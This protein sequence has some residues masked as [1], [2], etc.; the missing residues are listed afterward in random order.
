MYMLFAD[1]DL[2]AAEAIAKMAAGSPFSFGRVELEQLALGDRAAADSR[3]L[4]SYRNAQEGEAR[5]NVDLVGELCS[6]LATVAREKITRGETASDQQLRLYEDLALYHLYEKHR[7]S[8]DELAVQVE[9]S[10]SDHVDAPQ[11]DAFLEDHVA[12]LRP[13]GRTLS[14]AYDP[15]LLFAFFFQVRRAF[16]G[17]FAGFI[18]TSSS[19]GRLREA[20]WE[21][22]FSHDLHVY[23]LGL[24]DRMSDFAT[25]ITGE[26]GTGK[27]IVAGTIGRSGFVAFDTARRR[28]SSAFADAFTPVNLA[29]LSPTLV[30]SELFGHKKGS[31]TG[32]TTDRVGYFESCTK[33]GAVFLD[34]IGEIGEDLQV[35]LLRLLQDRRLSRIGEQRPRR[36]AGKVIAA[37]NRNLENAISE[38]GFRADLYYRLCGDVIR[39][40][41]LREQFADAPTDL[42]DMVEFVVRRLLPGRPVAACAISERCAK[43]IRDTLGD[44]YH[45][46]GNFRELE[47]CVRNL[48]LR[49]R[50]NSIGSDIGDTLAEALR[51][52]RCT[53]DELLSAQ[54]RAAYA[55]LG[56]YQAVAAELGIDRRTVRA[57]MEVPA[58]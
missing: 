57:K 27:E 51:D 50:Y 47:Q 35:K 58:K 32:A 52:V 55:R 36:F 53:A 16:R 6:R 23:L 39:T 43:Q 38:G 7:Q 30:E 8:F 33:H 45:W 5:N 9:E 15:A 29:A 12:W 21:S 17:I 46:P 25:L 22:I 54:C 31:F 4:W 20:A 41:S 14:R 11:W 37:T 1:P 34:E 19:A 24:H 13:N 18:G 48:I 49:G 56:T 42:D 44:G 28:F 40:P 3:P 10:P 2:V 26:S